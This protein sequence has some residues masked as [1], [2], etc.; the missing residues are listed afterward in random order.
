MPLHNP[1]PIKKTNQLN[2]L[3]IREIFNGI[4]R[5]VNKKIGM[6]ENG[7]SHVTCELHDSSGIKFGRCHPNVIKWYQSEPYQLV[8]VKGYLLHSNSEKW[9]NIIE[10]EPNNGKA[11]SNPLLSLP[12]ALCADSKNLDRLNNIRQS[13]KSPA[14]GKFLD[15]VFSDEEV[16][17]A[18]LQVPASRNHHHNHA[19]GL[20]AHSVEVAEIVA[21]ETFYGNY[22]REI[23][24]IAALLHDIGKVKTF[25]TNGTYT[26]LG[27]MVSHDHLTLEVCS[28]ALR[29]LDKTWPDASYTMRH[30]WTCASPGARY[31]FQPI[32]LIANI[33]RNADNQSCETFDIQKAYQFKLIKTGLL[34]SEHKQKYFWRPAA[35]PRKLKGANYAQH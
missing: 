25:N 12:K 27:K 17:L 7:T 10:I 9:V 11:Y 6:N 2:M 5:I 14:L 34:W 15:T 26:K 13:I 33:V 24:I 3:P 16:S 30:V 29:E 1:R 4:Y 31:G 22:E 21:N 18:F 23:A 20:L 32:C 28:T 19:G 35:E 8:N